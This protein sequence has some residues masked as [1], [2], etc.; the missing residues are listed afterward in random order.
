MTVNITCLMTFF[1]STMLG[2]DR[3]DLCEED[4][5]C[6]CG[7]SGL[8]DPLCAPPDVVE[9]YCGDNSNNNASRVIQKNNFFHFISFHF[10]SFHLIFFFC[11]FKSPL[12]F[13]LI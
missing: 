11:I 7:K 13:F 4:P 5:H 9:T 3:W 2:Q 8:T 1:A 12:H 10:I 6:L